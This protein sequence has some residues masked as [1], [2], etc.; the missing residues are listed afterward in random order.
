MFLLSIIEQFANIVAS[1]DASLAQI[2]AATF[3]TD[4]TRTGTMSS[5]PMIESA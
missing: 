4:N 5:T 1:K 3:N 2:L